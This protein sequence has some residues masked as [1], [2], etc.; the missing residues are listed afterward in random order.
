M[1]RRTIIVIAVLAALATPLAGCPRNYAGPVPYA[2]T[3]EYAA[4]DYEQVLVKW[5]RRAEVYDQFQSLAFV[6]ATFRSPDFRKAYTAAYARIMD[7]TTLEA[8]RLWAEEQAA[9]AASHEI[10][11][12]LYTTDRKWNDLDLATT[13]WK[14]RLSAPA[15]GTEEHPAAVTQIREIS[16]QMQRLF[17]HASPFTKFYVIRFPKKDAA[18]AETVPS[19]GGKVVLTLTSGLGKAEVEWAITP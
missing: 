9:A 3:R 14:V 18:G 11:V 12:A 5:T 10:M 4:D 7:L 1:T 2:A 17:P 15:T 13:I 19:G 6:T 16:P 8:G